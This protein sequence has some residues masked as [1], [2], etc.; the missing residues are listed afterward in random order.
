MSR[1]TTGAVAALGAAMLLGGVTA[2]AAHAETETLGGL[3]APTTHLQDT[4]AQQAVGG[5]T[6]ALGY[7]I[8]PVKELRL[9][10]WAGSGADVLNN[11]V[12]V[13]PDN[14]V[15]PVGTA[16]LTA[17]L[18]GGGGAEDLPLAGPLLGV[19]PG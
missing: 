16:P 7:A 13:V 4:D 3:P 2:Q 17:P 6:S 18:S 10:P 8:A 1:K 11:G 12:A 9:D 5:T 14:G 15:A 19:L